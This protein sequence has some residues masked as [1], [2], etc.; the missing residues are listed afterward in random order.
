MMSRIPWIAS[1]PP[2][3]KIAAPRIFF[4][5]A[6][7]AI[8]ISPCVSPFSMARPTLVIGR[9]P[10]R[11]LRPD[12]LVVVVGGMGKRA[13]TVA[14]AERPDARDVRRQAVIHFDVTARVHG[15]ASLVESQIAGVGL[16]SNGKEYVRP[17]NLWLTFRTIDADRHT[18][19]VWGNGDALGTRANADAF[20]D[21]NLSYRLRDVVVLLPGKARPFLDHSDLGAE[22]TIH[23]SELEAHVASADDDQMLGDTIERNHRR[24]REV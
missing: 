1:S 6:S 7:T 18:T 17:H 8:F 19:V 14:V 2:A 13:A 11:S 5:S 24:V 22:T 12:A 23:L 20:L 10:T 9:C 4:V 15:N 3:P 16:T 21:Q